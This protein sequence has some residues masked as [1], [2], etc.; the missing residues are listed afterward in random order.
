MAEALLRHYGAR[1]FIVASAGIAPAPTIAPLAH[2]TMRR[3]G[4]SL[5]DHYPKT[6]EAVLAPGQVW[7]YIITTCDAAREACPSFLGDTRRIHW[8]F[9][10]PA[11]TTGD[12]EMRLHAFRLVRDEI[13]RRVQ[14]FVA[15]SAHRRAGVGA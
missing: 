2:V 1:R 10:D 4:I 15:L 13:K 8:N 5:D 3:I 9:R 6:L 11:A 7:D 14:L 12:E